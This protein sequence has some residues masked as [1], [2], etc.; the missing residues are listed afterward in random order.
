MTIEL[1]EPHINQQNILDSNSRFRVVMCGRRFGKSELSQI[2]IISNALMGK[3]VAYITPTYKLAKTFFDQL[4]KVVSFD[5]NRSDLTIKFPNDGSIEFYTGERLDGLRGRKFHLAVI[6]EASFIPDL[7]EGWLNSIRPT[8]TDYKG[9][10]LFLSTP[11]GK[12]FFYSLYMK[13]ENRENDWESFKFTTYDNPYI[14]KSEVDDAKKQLPAVVFEQEYL[15]NP[16]ENSA[17]PFG[18]TYIRQC[19]YPMSIDKPIVFG[20]DLAKSFD[21]TV[22]IGLDKNGSVC[23]FERFQKD[24]K[25]TKEFI[26]NLPKAA[27]LIDSSGVGDPIFED[28]QRDGLDITGFRFSS[29][30][31]QQVMEGLAIGIQQRKISYPDGPIV[32]EL[33]IFEYIFS[34]NGVRY[35]APSGFHDDCVT[36]LALAWHHYSKNNMSGR[37][38]FA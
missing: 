18:T 11:K 23:Y 25:Q 27:I 38:S 15:A 12:N 21:F 33:E 5:S 3:R 10:G 35:S 36:A 7:E 32:S 17:N 2:E 22:I 28:L 37:Y 16:A 20:I 30:T 31:K 14:E 24:W 19:I 9:K 26:R 6:D 34:A 8:L 13:G 4:V 29:T 1:P